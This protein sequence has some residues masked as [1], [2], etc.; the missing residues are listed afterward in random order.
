MPGSPIGTPAYMSPEQAAGDLARLGPA[1]D[2]YS[3]GAT[4][5]VL[6]AGRPP[7]E[8]GDVPTVLDR[9]RRGDFPP[10]RR[11]APDVPA[12][13]D[14]ICLKAMAL[15][16]G[17]RYASPL[18]LAADLE[19]YLA[20]EPVTAHREP[21]AQ[22]ARRWVRR[23]PRLVTGTA[24]SAMVALVAF[25]A[26]TAVVTLANHRLADANGRI[27]RQRDQLVAAS[28]QIRDQNRRIE[29]QNTKLSESN[30]DLTLARG[31]AIRE[32]DQAEA[33]ADFFARNLKRADPAQDGRLVTVVDALGRSVAELDRRTDLD[34]DH[35]AFILHAASQTYSGLGLL[36]EAVAAAEQAAAIRVEAQGAD[37][38]ATLTA[39]SQLAGA[40]V[41]AGRRDEA[42]A[43]YERA[44]PAIRA[45][46]GADH[47]NT[48]WTQHNLARTL[49]DA[50]RLDEAL[51]L[52]ERT[53]EA[54]RARRGDAHPDT[55]D[56]L[57]RLGPAY[58]EAARYDDAERIYRE[59]IAAAGRAQPRNDR[60]YVDALTGLAMSLMARGEPAEAVAPLREALAIREARQPGG[61]LPAVTRGRLG[62]ALLAAGSPVEAEPLLLDAHRALDAQADQI[63]PAFRDRHLRDAVVRLIALYESR[64]DADRAAAWR[65][66]LPLPDDVFARP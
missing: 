7:V 55:L 29:G 23:H 62:E 56:V 16:P 44:L 24:A 54:S 11:V 30:R 48:L 1:S 6:L 43:L 2:V 22:R 45:A 37:H 35:R 38:P 57:G 4:L 21:I 50:G 31:E 39:Q 10:P 13:L 36:P 26:L 47:P 32:R 64:G 25:G 63:P 14:A 41:A 28:A 3:L 59:L 18:D 33:L 60:L 8:A 5:Y 61:W 65:R 40:Y 46:L 27:R 51:A 20:D 42:I 58:E 9:V 15:D 66:R 12:A 34:P 53:L 52:F 19:A 49:R 17:D